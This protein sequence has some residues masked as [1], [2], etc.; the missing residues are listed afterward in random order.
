MT[1][2]KIEIKKI[3]NITARQVTFSKRRRGLF[4]KAQEL[5]TLCDAQLAL[6]VFSST[7]KLY[8]YS[9]S[10]MQQVIK[11]HSLQS[12]YP[13]KPRQPSFDEL[14]RHAL[15]TREVAEKTMEIRHMKGEKLEN[16]NLEELKRLEKM[17]E[18]GL[19]RVIET[20]DNKFLQEIDS[21]KRKGV[22][23]FEEN[24][25][26]HQMAGTSVVPIDV[27]ILEQGESC[28]SITAISNPEDLDSSDTTLKLGLPFPGSS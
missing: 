10:S 14:Q 8:E 2:Q 13:E 1:R 23:L 24:K 28:E 5:S 12:E 18:T 17:I 27:E 7:G 21:L 26:L 4:K 20:K 9:S 15:L 11:R 6:I 25:H 22:Q 16:L 19:D 3:D